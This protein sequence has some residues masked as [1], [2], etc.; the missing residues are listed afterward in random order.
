MKNRIVIL[1]V[2]ILTALLCFYFAS[3]G[4]EDTQEN[5]KLQPLGNTDILNGIWWCQPLISGGGDGQGTPGVWVFDYPNFWNLNHYGNAMK[6]T[7]T[8]SGGIDKNGTAKGTSIPTLTRIKDAGGGTGTP[9][10]YTWRD[11]PSTELDAK[12]WELTNDNKLS[13]DGFGFPFLKADWAFIGDPSSQY[14]GPWQAKI[15]ETDLNTLINNNLP[16]TPITNT[17]IDGLWW[18]ETLIKN[19]TDPGVWAIYYPDFWTLNS[20]GSANKGTY[21][22][23][24]GVKIDNS[25]VG[26]VT[27]TL[28]GTKTGS[29]WASIPPQAI[30]AVDISLSSDGRTLTIGT[31]VFH[32][33]SWYNKTTNIADNNGP[34]ED[35]ID[36]QTLYETMPVKYGWNETTSIF[37]LPPFVT[38]PAAPAVIEYNNTSMTRDLFTNLVSGA[39]ELAARW[40]PKDDNGAEA[41]LINIRSHWIAQGSRLSLRVLRTAQYLVF[42]LGSNFSSFNKEFC[43]QWWSSSDIRGGST[44]WHYPLSSTITS[45]SSNF[46][47]DNGLNNGLYWDAT[48]RLMIIDLPKALPEYAVFAGA[49]TGSLKPDAPT[50]D[51]NNGSIQIN[52]GFRANMGVFRDDWDVQNVY[53]V[54]IVD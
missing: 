47:A 15:G 31:A 42:E 48:N 28:T 41:R 16:P 52:L 25:A 21:T 4:G 30:P 36:D 44:G 23:T 39:T 8:L 26:S 10:Y 27:G 46:N 49:N 22:I 11:V 9:T 5:E 19:G 35:K 20:A 50:Y 3:C 12:T 2:S 43:L 34:W 13:I 14:N 1:M 40:G 37:T 17:A 29:S 7:Y 51:I 45:G 53:L 54:N 6:G 32:K 24:G 33:T 18:N 38:Q